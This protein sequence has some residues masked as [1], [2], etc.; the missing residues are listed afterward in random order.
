MVEH[1][2]NGKIPSL[3]SRLKYKDAFSCNKFSFFKI[4]VA[5]ISDSE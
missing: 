4:N 2:P 1:R 5:I 3:G